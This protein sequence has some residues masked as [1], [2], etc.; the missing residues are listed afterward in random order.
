M[1][2][3]GNTVFREGIC[4][5][6]SKAG[7]AGRSRKA[8]LDGWGGGVGSSRGGGGKGG[9]VEEGYYDRGEGDL[10]DNGSGSSGGCVG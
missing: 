6:V 2:I 4:E 3:L 1:E 5:G 10:G 8:K 9:G 7:R